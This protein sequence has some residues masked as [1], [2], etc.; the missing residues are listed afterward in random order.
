MSLEEVLE[1]A[2]LRMMGAVEVLQDA[3]RGLRSGRATA[4]LVDGLEVEAYG[5][6]SPLKS[7]ANVATPD[8]RLIVIRPF[9]PSTIPAIEKAIQA[10]ELGL[11]PSSDGKVIRLSVPPLSEERRRQMASLAR[12]KGEEAKIAIRNVRRDANKEIDRIKKDGEAP[13]DDCFKA[14]DRLQEITREQEGEVDE[15]VEKKVAEIS[16]V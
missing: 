7:L 2:E 16:E 1:D 8:A 4:G 10:S 9:D 5:T 12:S 11:N 15:L 14:K 3:L 13:E 6:T